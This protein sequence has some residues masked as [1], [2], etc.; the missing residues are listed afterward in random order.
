V[1]DFALDRRL[2]WAVSWT[3]REPLERSSHALAH[4]G[5]VWLIDPVADEAA[6]LAALEL[7]EPAAVVQLLD[8]H[9][10]DCEAL[11][12]RFGVAH[13]R[14]PEQLE[15]SP[16][17]IHRMVWAPKWRE[18]CLWWEDRQALLVPEAVGRSDYMAVAG[19]PLGVH[20]F[21]RLRPP[22][23]LRRFT[24]EVL[25]AGHGPPLHSGATEA[26]REALARSRADI[27][28]AAAA[29]VRGARA[30]AG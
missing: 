29:M 3:A 18:L 26:L 30:A 2:P 14:L 27:P 16:F 8:R 22:G 12:R 5:R 24:P 15:E 17:S 13:V 25:L 9:P 1:T 11:A 19:R 20:P 4:D 21:L 6:L 28:R 7:G 23:A 10:R